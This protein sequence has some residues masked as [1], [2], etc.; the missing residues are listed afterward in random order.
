MSEEG[1]G[2]PGREVPDGLSNVVVLRVKS[3]SSGGIAGAFNWKAIFLAQ[4]LFIYLL[5]YLNI[6]SLEDILEGTVLFVSQTLQS[7]FGILQNHNTVNP[8][9]DTMLFNCP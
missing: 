8:W 6:T 2:S 3:R 7:V 1:F 5:T 4:I 9:R